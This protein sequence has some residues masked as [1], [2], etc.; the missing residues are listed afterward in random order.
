MSKEVGEF[1]KIKQ[2][3]E[4]EQAGRSWKFGLAMHQSALM[5]KSPKQTVTAQ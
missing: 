3:E 1:L 5:Q 2:A 4:S